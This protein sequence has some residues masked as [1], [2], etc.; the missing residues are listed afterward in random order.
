MIN[1]LV[2]SAMI[3]CP[4]TD[5]SDRYIPAVETLVERKITQG[6]TETQ[7]GTH[8]HI[9]RIDG[10]VMINKALDIYEVRPNGSVYTDVPVR[11][12][13]EINALWERNII[14]DRERLN[15]EDPMTRKDVAEAL[16][17]AYTYGV[18]T[19]SWKE[20]VTN[21]GLFK[22]DEERGMRWEEPVTRGEFA[23]IL[24]RMYNALGDYND[25]IYTGGNA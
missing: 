11:A 21:V 23:L 19:M 16:Y 15:S 17:N 1:G 6:I 2:L 9:K 4:F 20:W 13:Q 22:G 25:I 5:V 7:Y 18:E 3:A 12:E 24:E 14:E 8:E 10:Y